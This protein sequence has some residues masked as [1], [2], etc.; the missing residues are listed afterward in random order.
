MPPAV[1]LPCILHYL[2]FIQLMNTSGSTCP[3]LWLLWGSCK[4]KPNEETLNEHLILGC[5]H[6]MISP[7]RFQLSLLEKRKPLSL[8][9]CRQQRGSPLC[10]PTCTAPVS[11]F[12]Q[13]AE[14][15]C[16]TGAVLGRHHE[17]CVS[18]EQFS[19]G[20]SWVYAQENKYCCSG[21]AFTFYLNVLLNL[22]LLFLKTGYVTLIKNCLK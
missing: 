5:K 18:R 1:F 14:H 16:R 7:P 9:P 13:P 10:S 3:V 22:T 15:G 6:N 21:W 12:L 4:T 11:S 20:P 2:P 8:L 17:I 19:N